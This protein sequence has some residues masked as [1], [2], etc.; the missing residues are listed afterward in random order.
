MLETLERLTAGLGDR[1]AVERELGRG[2][3]ATVFLARDLKH[4][5]DVAIKVLHPELA[6]TIGSERFEREIRLAAKLQHPHILGLYDSGQNDG[7]FYYVMP[8]VKGEAL[9]DR[10]D[11]EGQLPV[12]DAIRITLEVADALGYAHEQGIFHR[13]IKPENILLSGGH[14]LVADFGIARA[15][16]EAGAQKLTQTGMA[17]GTPVYMSPEQATGEHVGP[18]ADIYSLGCVLY[19]M[20][21]GEPPFTG[22]NAMAIMARHA[23]EN[24]PSIRIV[25]TAV[26]EEVEDAIFAAMGK[27]PADR[28]QTAAQFAEILGLPLG[29]T[30]ARRA[31]GRTASR[32]IPTQAI[33]A[34]DAAPARRKNR[35][36]IAAGLGLALLAGGAV[37]VW[38]LG[39]LKGSAAAQGSGGLDPRNIAVLYFSA[40]R[41][42][43]LSDLAD[44]L[45]S[46]VIDQL[47]GVQGL[48]VV[49]E[50]GVVPFRGSDIRPDSI[51]RVLGAGTI[52]QGELAPSRA[53]VSLTVQIFEGNGGTRLDSESYEF[54][55]NALTLGDSAAAQIAALL[56]KRVG[57]EVRV[58]ARRAAT[59][60]E[61]A[62]ALTHRAER[63]IREAERNGRARDTTAVE[64]ALLEADSLLGVVEK[65]DNKWVEPIVLRGT[66]AYLGAR[67]GANRA[68]MVP[69]VDSGFARARRAMTLDERDAGAFELRGTLAL[70]RWSKGLESNATAQARLLDQAEADLKRAT[71]L[72]GSRASAWYRL[73]SV[74]FEK[75]NP[76]EG[77]LAT[78]RAYDTD[79]FLA[80][81]DAILWRLYSTS[82]DNE[83]FPDAVNRCDEGQRR[84][85]ADW[86]FV[87]CQLQLFTTN[88]RQPD[89]ATAWRLQARLTELAPAATR[90]FFEREG[91]MLVAAT[92]A[93]A[94]Q[95]D[96]ARRL[97]VAA[98]G[99]NE[100]DPDHALMINEAF[101]R[102]LMGDRGEALQLLRQYLSLHPEHRAGFA[103][104]KMWWWRN[105]RTDQ[106]FKD[107]VGLSN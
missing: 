54:P 86:K 61:Q 104:S 103:E 105:L 59:S 14:A 3:M 67:Y 10:L 95:K 50:N 7:L 17:V 26:P 56:R 68:L 69:R 63:L 80:E 37:A 20:L 41:G 78:R 16:S 101:I 58:T 53:G 9:R 12:D 77:T 30:A 87:R 38:Q 24:V 32:R 55:R 99:D 64:R 18:T 25:R 70:F 57:D 31:L 39:A 98:R 6:A 11:R 34:M 100:I 62:W 66:V 35:V 81:A 85:P 40:G 89:P 13:D 4:D 75:A 72:D 51:A 45:T 1:Y 36:W 49:S 15:A 97:L 5:R 52:V 96:S 60:N 84:F 71:Q 47:R 91:K 90:P 22:K 106:S 107:M 94:Q 92:L 27:V 88:I 8:F 44:G 93:R 48:N 65:L 73:A 21:A 33:E 42:G 29:S 2:G 82:Y 74:Y 102:E 83:Q 76:I 19:E 46:E 28:P 43:E 79:A 23:M